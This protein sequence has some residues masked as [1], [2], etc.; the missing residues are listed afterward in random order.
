M[1]ACVV[2]ADIAAFSAE[3]AGAVALLLSSNGVA[4][5]AGEADGVNAGRSLNA[6]AWQVW[7]GAGGQPHA[8]IGCDAREVPKQRLL[9]GMPDI[10]S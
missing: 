3:A 1:G 7:L 4:G 6:R 10:N 5:D 8:L 9:M 2:G